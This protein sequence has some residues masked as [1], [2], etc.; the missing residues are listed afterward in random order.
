MKWTFRWFGSQSDSVQLSH[1]KQVP[2]VT[3]IMGFLD[4]KAAGEV[5]EEA[6]IE[7]YIGEVREAGLDCEVI[8][9]VNVHEDIKL[10]L[11]SRDMYIEN[12]RATVRNLSRYGVRVVIYN[13]MPVLDWLR[14][15][16]AR[17]IPEDGSSSLY[18]NENDLGD[19]GPLEIVSN[20]A[21]GAK[22]F[23]LPGWEPERLAEL[24]KT[25]ALYKPV[26][27]DSLL[28]NFR[29]FLNGILPVC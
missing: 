1:I 11:P 16:L 14:T 22:G 4:A 5:W 7:A 28:E 25:L 19:M 20:T 26:T 10:G 8:E 24:D 17:V 13:F 18:F 3:G 2:G 12:Y 15:D 6:E 21:K 23:S 29:Y 27:P 9:S